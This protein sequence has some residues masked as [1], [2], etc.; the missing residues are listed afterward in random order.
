MRA[1]YAAELGSTG[2]LEMSRFHALSAGKVG[3]PPIEAPTTDPGH[4]GDV[5]RKP[6]PGWD[7]GDGEGEGSG[8]DAGD[9]G[10]VDASAPGDPAAAAVARALGLTAAGVASAAAGPLRQALR[11]STQATSVACRPRRARRRRMLLTHPIISARIGMVVT[12][13]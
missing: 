9:G 12:P 2:A 1:T 10:A 13:G 8:V 7:E 4:G 6:E 5:G 11:P 3:H